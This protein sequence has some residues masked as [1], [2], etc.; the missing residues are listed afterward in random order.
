[1]A[2]DRDSPPA[3]PIAT[4][5]ATPSPRAVLVAAIL[6][7]VGILVL[8][9]WVGD[10]LAPET[11][12]GLPD[13]G[14]LTPWALP[15]AKF[16]FDLSALA[17][18]GTLLA[19]VALVPSA[20]AEMTAPGIRCLRAAAVWAAVWAASALVTF[21]LSLSDILGVPAG[22]VLDANT[23]TSFAGS[24]SQG[25]ALLFVFGLAVVIAA[26]APFVLSL[27]AGA[28]LLVVSG[29]ALLPVPLTGHAAGA[30]DHDVATSSLVAHVV[31]GSLWVGGLLAL[32]LYVRRSR[33]ALEVAVPRFSALALWC[34]VAIGFSGL[35]N[36]WV[37]LG[38]VDDL[39]GSRYGLLVLGKVAAFVV[40]GVFGW[41]HRRASRPFLR[42]AAGEVVVMAAT[43]GLAVALS[44]I[45]T[46]VPDGATPDATAAASLL[47]F[48]LPPYSLLE[49]L[50]GWRPDALVLLV[51][52][53]ALA[54]Y[55][56]G[57]LRL[58]R[59]GLSWP[60][61]RTLAWIGGLAVATFVLNSGLAAYGR[62][63][64][65]AHMLQHMTLTMIVPILLGMGAP[66]TLALRALPAH[67]A[68]GPRGARE[69]L[70]VILHSRIARFLTHPVVALTLYVVTLY[71]FYFTPLFD[72]SHRS[73]LAHALMHLHFIAI[74][75]LYFWP[76]LGIDPMPRRLPPL[77]R[78]LLL[79]ASV[80]FHA[81]FGVALMSSSTVLSEEWYASLG[82][83]WVG[84]LL[85]DQNVG[86]GIAWSF[87]EIPTL[88]VLAAIFVQW[89]RADDRE[90]KRADRRADRDGDAELAAYN[91]YLSHLNS[92]STTA[93]QRDRPGAR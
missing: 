82:L 19:G 52:G 50:T 2:V 63:L 90:A 7:G 64:F 78:I 45:R 57:V 22:D 20:G 35:L 88:L 33:A 24:I 42:F 49:V 13:A 43:V 84:S 53:T 14:A 39:W 12:P 54:L 36:A 47:G 85:A 44:R 72:L 40:L 28:L 25:R 30:A 73:H 79:F 87:G 1:M 18:V 16:V 67:R 9:L 69:W 60:V 37:R 58:S 65:S 21:V 51:T 59:R 61:G 27:D 68:D 89:Y 92:S 31:A 55:V 5:A 71:G 83:P 6:A 77:G 10:A 48:D 41:W 23:L 74:G 29:V 75:C 66:I 56:G 46:P 91:D 15:I 81:F 4:D 32:V 76:I 3:A 17:T 8:G 26:A 38:G 93:A 70:L 34:Y 86:A 62:A 11:I 80:P